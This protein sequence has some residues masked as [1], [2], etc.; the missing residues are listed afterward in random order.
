MNH[1]TEY[2]NNVK[3]EIMQDPRE[4]LVHNP[5]AADTVTVDQAL[6][7]RYQ[8]KGDHVEEHIEYEIP[9]DTSEPAPDVVDN[10]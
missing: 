3:E 5:P 7:P 4:S 2:I 10:I 1:I 8:P 6:D 9:D